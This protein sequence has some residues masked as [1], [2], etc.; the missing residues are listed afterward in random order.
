MLYERILAH[1]LEWWEAAQKRPSQVL[2]LSLEEFVFDLETGVRRL[3]DFTGL[4]VDDDAVQRTTAAL[5]F[6]LNCCC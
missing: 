5:E 2:L 4:P 1:Y 6:L 3:I